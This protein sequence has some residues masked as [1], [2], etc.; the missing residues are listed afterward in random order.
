[1]STEKRVYRVLDDLNIHYKRFEHPPVFTVEE[2]SKLANQAP[3]QDCKNL[4]IRNRKG[5]THYLLIA[6]AEEKVN[7]KDVAKQIGSTSLSLASKERLMKHLSLEPGS[8]SPFG[9]V[10][11]NEKNIVVLVDSGLKECDLVTFHPNINT[12]T[13]SLSFRD[14]E[15]FFQWYGNEINY[16]KL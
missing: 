10:N 15:R 5:N 4:F 3:G 13:L 1:M 11:N 9:L 7:L 16:V 8:V 12:V 2:A 14:L 6:R